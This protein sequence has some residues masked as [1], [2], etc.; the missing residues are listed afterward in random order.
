MRQDWHALIQEYICGII[1][2]ADARA[3]ERQL[4][5]DAELRDWYLDALNLDSALAAA[6]EASEMSRS[7]PLFPVAAGGGLW[8]GPIRS[9]GPGPSRGWKAAV[10]MLILSFFAAPLV[11]SGRGVPVEVLRVSENASCGLKQGQRIRAGHLAWARGSVELL[12]ASGV[13]ASIDG[14]AELDVVGPLE[15]RLLAGK[16]TAD[17]G[18]RGKGFVIETPE[19]RVVDLGTVFGVDATS[20][21]STNVVVFNGK[22]EVYEKGAFRPLVLLS[23]GEGLRLESNRRTSRIVSVNGPDEAGAWSV[24]A[25]R[26]AAAL[27]TA[28]SDS[29]STDEEGAKKWPSL[30]N[31]YRIVPGGLRDGASAFADTA[32]SWS[33]VPAELIG[34]DQVRTF[35]VDR[36]NWWMRLALEISRP[37][38]LFVL[39]DQRNPVPSWVSDSFVDTG[40]SV[41]LDIR[42]DHDRGRI[43]GRI[44]Y[45]IW[46]RR[47]E[48]PGRYLLGAPYENPPEDRKSF[49][50]NNMFGIV[51]R[52]IP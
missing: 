6:A 2:E 36:F 52:E 17:V 39:V 43:V 34:A 22:V 21:A 48:N 15:I 27:I 12:F 26:P 25:Q 8:G 4:K 29:M 33:D 5:S 42:P 16:V 7:I 30:R 45:S 31:F 40:K 44:P 19:A 24:Q 49:K 35:A 9:A 18:E 51:A 1:S 28:V 50:P 32:D 37:C 38:E 3:L 46:S 41:M 20:S 10:A 14:P 23:Q 47:V 11:W 13:K